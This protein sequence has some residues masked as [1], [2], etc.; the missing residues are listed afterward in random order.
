MAVVLKRVVL[1]ITTLVVVGGVFAA[2]TVF[3][4]MIDETHFDRPDKRFDR[5]TAALDREPGVRVDGKERWVEAPTFSDPTSWIRLT[6][7]ADHLRGLLATACDEQ[8]SGTVAWS[9]R[10]PTKNGSVVSLYTEATPADRDD[11]APCPDFGIDAVGL[12]G[13]V[14]RSV[15]GLDLQ[16]SVWDTGHFRLA[17]LD[18]DAGPLTAMLPLVDQADELRA[19]AALDPSLSIQIDTGS[20]SAVIPPDEHER[21][22]AL[23]SDLAENHGV[24]SYWADGG[25]APSDGVE[26][27]QITAPDAEHAGIENTIRSS[28]LHV[29]DFPVRFLARTP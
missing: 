23:L 2:V 20:L 5:L 7:E 27:V 6:V 13:E 19:A 10:A 8:Y 24:T 12:V 28:G 14:G 29:A 22:L 18:A 17:V 1:S 25:G 11:D 26:K 4:W 21:Y 16:A 3:A 9:L 15:P